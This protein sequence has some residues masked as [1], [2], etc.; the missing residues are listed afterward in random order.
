MRKLVIL[1]FLV[2]TNFSMVGQTP[3]YI[4]FRGGEDIPSSETYHVIQDRKGYIW[5]AT[6][7][8]VSRFDG[9]EF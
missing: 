6:A 1:F 4:H 2:L 5:I 7:N 9:Y 3:P 8:G